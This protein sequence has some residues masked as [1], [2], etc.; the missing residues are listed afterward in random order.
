MIISH[1][2][3]MRHKWSKYNQSKINKRVGDIDVERGRN[4]P[5]QRKREKESARRRKKRVGR[6][7][8]Q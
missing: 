3:H 1:E 4:R 5:G 8:D 7:E 6:L 2:Y